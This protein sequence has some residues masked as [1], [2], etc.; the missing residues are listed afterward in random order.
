MIVVSYYFMRA[1]F[2]IFPKSD[3]SS[4]ALKALEIIQAVMAI[5]VVLTVVYSYW[6]N[7]LTC[8]KYMLFLQA[9]QMMLSNFNIYS[10]N[11]DIEATAMSEGEIV[12]NEDGY[13]NSEGLNM[14]SSV[15]SVMFNLFNTLFMVFVIDNKIVKFS[16]TAIIF[17]LQIVILI[18]TN[19][20]FKNISGHAVIALAIAIVYQGILVPAFLFLTNSIMQETIDEANINQ[21]QRN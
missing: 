5:I 10:S 4:P 1:M 8:I 17:V 2:I 14:L 7:E 20:T 6:F 18:A 9:V 12:R 15:Y 11:I 3:K 13:E 19:F 21:E 16:L